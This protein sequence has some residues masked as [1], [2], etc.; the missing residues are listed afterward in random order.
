MARNAATPADEQVRL[1][2]LFDILS[3]RSDID[4]PI[5]VECSDTIVAGLKRRLE[6]ATAERDAYMAFLKEH[7]TTASDQTSQVARQEAELRKQQDA[8]SR[9]R[10]DETD[11]QAELVRLEVEKAAVD[12]ELLALETEARQL[13]REEEDFWRVRNSFAAQLDTLQSERDSVMSRY[14]HDA[15]LYER[16]TRTNV[17]NDTFSISHDGTYATVNGL[18]L[19]RLSAVPVD[20]PEINA[21]WGHALL[22]LVTVAEKLGYKFVGYEAQPM[23]S[24]SRIFKVEY[25]EISQSSSSLSQAITTSATSSPASSSLHHSLHAAP[26]PKKTVLELYCAGDMLGLLTIHRSFNNAMVAFLEMVRQLGEFVRTQMELR[27][28]S[29]GL[30][31][32]IE[33]DKINDNSIRIG[34]MGSGNDEGWTKA[35]KLTLTCCKFLLAHA[36]NVGSSPHGSVAEGRT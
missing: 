5:C 32:S 18:R 28:Q 20:W 31:Y 17:H 9:A 7:R 26:A 24:T 27:G 12:A 14:E 3:A 16:L 4:H 8:L 34:G 19:G 10:A 25:P 2:R 23:G 13:D 21:A 29:L 30:P 33:G 11:A 36:S 22:L 15:R 6:D 35:C 1:N